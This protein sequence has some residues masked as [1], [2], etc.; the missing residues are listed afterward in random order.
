[1]QRVG[2]ARALARRPKILLADEATSALDPETTRDV[3]ALLKQ[4]NED[5]GI[6]IIIITHAMD[7]VRYVCDRVA[8]MEHGHVIEMGDVYQVFA[9][10]KHPT[11]RRFVGTALRDRPSPDVLA[12]LRESYP[13]IFVHIEVTD[14]DVNDPSMILD[15]LNAHGVRGTIVYGGIQAVHNRPFG[16][17]T[18]SLTGDESSIAGAIRQLQEY[19]DVEV[20]Q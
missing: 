7:V 17:L 2:I 12:A 14:T 18:F 6:T 15:T 5:L 9:E 3:L 13:G 16:S 20:L 11:T 10:P 19:T 1:M 4:V 8:V